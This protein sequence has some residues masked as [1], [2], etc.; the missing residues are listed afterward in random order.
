VKLKDFN[1]G[2]GAIALLEGIVLKQYNQ[3]Y[4]AFTAS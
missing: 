3:N 4:T 2:L 1:S